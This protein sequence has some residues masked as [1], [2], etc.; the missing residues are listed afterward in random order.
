ME[1]QKKI[2][3]AKQKIIANYKEQK[4]IYLEEGYKEC[5][6]TFSVLTANLMAFVVTAPFMMIAVG[7]WVLTGGFRKSGYYEMNLL[8]VFA[9]MIASIFIHEL[10]HGT[11][12]IGISGKSW[13]SIYIGVMWESLTPD[14]HCKEPLSPREYFVGAV[15]PFVVLG[16]GTYLLALAT[17]SFMFFL[18]SL[19]NTVSAGG[20]L[21]IVC[22]EFKYLKQ[23][24]NCLIL[25]HP[26]DCG[27]IAFIKE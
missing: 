10:L 9:L 26:E 20:D 7:G 4:K 17:G 2:H 12:W 5:P 23:N 3:P 6:E 24:E 22:K 18:L 1:K 25:D 8:L 13:K 15:M 21:L 14:C 27:F 11:G 19:F 16:A